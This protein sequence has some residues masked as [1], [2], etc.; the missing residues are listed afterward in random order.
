[1]STTGASR[2][3]PSAYSQKPWLKHYDFWVP[4]EINF[5]R[6]PIYQILDLAALQ[7]GDRPATA[8]CEAHLTFSEIKAQVDRLA[9]AL[10]RLGVT[11]GERVGIMLPNCPQYL[12]GLFAI[13]RLGAIVA[14]VNP[15]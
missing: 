15:T 4:A 9:T 1:M 8:F 10:A 12:I 5:P 13:V 11:K 2:R 3:A 14:N 6:Q 7:F